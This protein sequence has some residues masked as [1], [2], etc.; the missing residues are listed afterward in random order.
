AF[1]SKL[2]L[3]EL[4]NEPAAAKKIGITIVNPIQVLFGINQ[5]STF[6]D[7]R[8]QSLEGL[9][10]IGFDGY[11]IGGLSVGEEKG[12]MFEVV[13]HIAPKMPE[14]RPRYLMGVG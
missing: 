3:T 11:A 6:V 2:R 8:E 4:H 12:A 1:R 13:S 5:G 14:D 9:V 10:E 7:L